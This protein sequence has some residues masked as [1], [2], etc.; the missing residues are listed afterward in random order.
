MVCLWFLASQVLNVIFF[1]AALLKK[2][3]KRIAE[4]PI[5]SKELGYTKPGPYIYALLADLNIRHE[6]AS[7]LTDIL[8]AASTLVEEDNQENSTGNICRLDSIREILDLVFRDGE[9]THAKYYRVSS[10]FLFI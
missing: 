5:E 2:L 8:E 1:V 3:E 7:K 10:G 9:T 4:V 6:T